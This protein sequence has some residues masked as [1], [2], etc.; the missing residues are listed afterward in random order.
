MLTLPFFSYFTNLAN[1]LCHSFYY[2]F[3]H[4]FVD[5]IDKTENYV[6][7]VRKSLGYVYM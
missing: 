7:T 1:H 2:I 6:L 4:N 3:M 5:F